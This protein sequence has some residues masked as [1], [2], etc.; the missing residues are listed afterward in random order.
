MNKQYIYHYLFF[1]NFLILLRGHFLEDVLLCFCVNLYTITLVRNSYHF[2]I[3]LLNLWGIH[4]M[5]PNYIGL[6]TC[7]IPPSFLLHLCHK[8]KQKKVLKQTSNSNNKKTINHS[9]SKITPETAKICFSLSPDSPSPLHSFWCIGGFSVSDSIPFC[10]IRFI[11]ERSLQW[12]IY[13]VQGLW[14]FV[15]HL[16]CIITEALQ[17][18][19]S[20]GP[21][22]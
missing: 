3:S 5:H 11:G 13:L 20:C 7:H 1:P 10:P 2:L 6:L 16:H 22:C 21:G 9:G 15:H 14:F 8:R 12:V 17:G 19:P 18:N 4:T